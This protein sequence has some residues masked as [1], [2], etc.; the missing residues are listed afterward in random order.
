MRV[1]H[2]R[3]ELLSAAGDHVRHI[4]GSLA[5]AMVDA[6]TAAVEHSNGKVRSIKLLHCAASHLVRIGDSST[7]TWHLPP[8]RRERK[9]G[10][11]RRRVEAPHWRCRDYES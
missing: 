10:L 3:I 7:D 11:R 8:V 2:G 4:P 1:F 5:R 6:G 9:A